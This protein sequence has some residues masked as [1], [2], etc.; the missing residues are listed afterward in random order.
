VPRPMVPE[1][2]SS[3]NPDQPSPIPMLQP[4]I[5]DY[6]KIMHQISPWSV[7]TRVIMLR[8]F[9]FLYQFKFLLDFIYLILNLNHFCFI[10]S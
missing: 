6:Y 9:L 8:P 5:E 4:P 3:E 7:V 10:I 1:F 2:N